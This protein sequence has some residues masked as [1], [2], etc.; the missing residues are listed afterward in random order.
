MSLALT[1]VDQNLLDSPLVGGEG[2]VH[3]TTSTTSGFRGRKVTTIMAASGL[4]GVINWRE[5]KF[6][7]NGVQREWD[8]LKSRSGGIFSSCVASISILVCGRGRLIVNSY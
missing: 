1:F 4:V 6:V 7:I 2:A 8:D 5:K 3:Y